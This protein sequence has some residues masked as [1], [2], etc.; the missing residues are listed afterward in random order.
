MAVLAASPNAQ[1]TVVAPADWGVMQTVG[2]NASI[3]YEFP[4]TAA[5]ALTVSCQIVPSAYM[6]GA[7]QAGYISPGWFHVDHIGSSSYE[8]NVIFDM[9]KPYT[10]PFDQA[11][12]MLL[13]GDVGRGTEVADY[14]PGGL[15]TAT[16]VWNRGNNTIDLSVDGPNGHLNRTVGSSGLDVT[17]LTFVGPNDASMGTS[18]F[19]NVVVTVPEPASASLLLVAAGGLL[20]RRRRP[21]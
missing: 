17:G 15:Y 11:Y 10:V 3:T 14:V 12:T 21:A 13:L 8:A 7:Y 4:V 19:G 2:Q 16:M 6:P 18:M 5:S 9:A 20:V 1:A